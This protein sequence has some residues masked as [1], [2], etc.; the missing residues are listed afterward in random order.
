[1]QGLCALQTTGDERTAL[2][3]ALCC[4]LRAL[5]LGKEIGIQRLYYCHDLSVTFDEAKT[6]SAEL[7]SCRRTCLSVSAVGGQER[8]NEHV[9]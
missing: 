8:P 1:M 5:R 6:L 3:L 7:S 9:T 2:W 4:A